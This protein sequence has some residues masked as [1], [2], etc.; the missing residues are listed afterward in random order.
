VILESS[1]KHSGELSI[2]QQR[3]DAADCRACPLR[4]SGTQTVYG[5]G[6]ATAKIMIV[7]EQPGDKED[8]AGR[9][10]IGPAGKLLNETLEKAGL[11]RNE[12][13]ITNAVKHFK[14]T[15]DPHGKYR[16]SQQPT[17]G[18][19][20]AC[21]QWLDK[22]RNAIKPAII[23]CLGAVAAHG[24]L[25]KTFNLTRQR[26]QWLSPEKNYSVIVTWHPSAILRS[27]SKKDW[28]DRLRDFVEDLTKVSKLSKKIRSEKFS[29]AKLK[30][31][32]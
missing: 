9:P 2:K 11:A 32:A 18:E 20:N 13:Y 22:E 28:E 8:L 27:Y 10:F 31:A 25:G 24:I 15:R 14:W 6:P 29:S 3:H 12:V 30:R 21:R 4:K 16:K 26:S 5:E 19:I 17:A 7:G 1:T 23:V